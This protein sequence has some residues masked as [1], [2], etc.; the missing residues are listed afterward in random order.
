MRKHRW[1]ECRCGCGQQTTIAT[2]TDRAKKHIKGQPTHYVAGHQPNGKLLTE[3]PRFQY[4][5]YQRGDCWEWRGQ[6]NSAGY[7]VFRVWELQVGAHRYAY[8]IS[9][10]MIPRTLEVD[11][12]CRHRWC[13][14]P[15]HLEAVTASQNVRRG[16]SPAAQRAQQTHCKRGHLFD[17]DNTLPGR[18]RQCRK[19]KYM[20]NDQWRM[21]RA[22]A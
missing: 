3:L 22:L 10:G 7:G 8:E 14:R 4:K 16:S 21:R 5:V 13:V 17:S 1:G 20:L 15:S 12:L 11:H 19:C 18:W 6:I 2:Q 9:K